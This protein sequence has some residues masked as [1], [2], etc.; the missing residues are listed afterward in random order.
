VRIDHADGMITVSA[1]SRRAFTV[2]ACLVAH[3]ARMLA[4]DAAV[5]PHTPIFVVYSAREQTFVAGPIPTRYRQ[6]PQS[7]DVTLTGGALT[8]PT[9]PDLAIGTPQRAARGYRNNPKLRALVEGLGAFIPGVTAA[10][11]Y[12]VERLSA[13]ERQRREALFEYLDEAGAE[14]TDELIESE[15]FLHCFTITMRAAQQTRRT[16]KIR[17][18]ARLLVSTIRDQEQTVSDVDEYE[19]F[20]G[21]LDDMSV[22]EIRVMAVLDRFQARGTLGSVKWEDRKQQVVDEIGILPDEIDGV[23][24]RLMRTGLY[25]EDVYSLWGGTMTEGKLTPRWHRLRDLIADA[26]GTVI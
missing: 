7:T 6:L 4:G 5:P 26:E 11:T 14:L 8:T 20:L 12:I 13:L 25:S 10:N 21:I 24:V 18:L 22:R 2:P 23:L 19:E 16:E 9:P 17:L 1:G 15:D 3:D